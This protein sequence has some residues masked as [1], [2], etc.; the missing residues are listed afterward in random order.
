MSSNYAYP[1]L[2]YGP[3]VGRVDILTE[4][5]AQQFITGDLKQKPYYLAYEQ[6]R[7]VR[8]LCDA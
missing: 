7:P 6:G 8:A 3:N 4:K 2:E 1:I 5:T